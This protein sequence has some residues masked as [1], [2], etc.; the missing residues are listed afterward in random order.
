MK[1]HYIAADPPAKTAAMLATVMSANAPANQEMMEQ[2]AQQKAAQDQRDTMLESRVTQVETAATQ[3]SEV[4]GTLGPIQDEAAQAHAQIHAA[5]DALTSSQAQQDTQIASALQAVTSAITTLQAKVQALESRQMWQEFGQGMVS[6]I[7][8]LNGTKDVPVVWT[9][10]MPNTTY[11][12]RLVS[13]ADSLIGKLQL[14]GVKD[15]TRTGCTA[16]VRALLAL[17]LT[18]S[19]VFSATTLA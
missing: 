18:G 8:I 7:V 1:R 5:L 4:A 9:G 16:T 10:Q 19:V 3:L 2:L 13:M 11:Q 15:V 12:V 17:T 14:V 6:G